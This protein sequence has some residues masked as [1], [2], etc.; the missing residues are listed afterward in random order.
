MGDGQR[1]SYTF[2]TK[3]ESVRAHVE[4]G[5]TAEAAM[6]EWGVDSK[7]AF[8]RWCATYRAEGA[9]ALRPKKRGRPKRN[10]AE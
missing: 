8:F 2:E 6:K 9:E 10:T 3:L 7:S 4:D 5:L 1:K